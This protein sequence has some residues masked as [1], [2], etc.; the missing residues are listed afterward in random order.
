MVT[1][2]SKAAR[3]QVLWDAGHKTVAALMSRANIARRTAERYLKKLKAGESLDR[4]RYKTR[5][6][7]AQTPGIIRKV[8]SKVR[9]SKRA[10]SIR[11]I[12]TASG[13]SYGTVRTILKKHGSYA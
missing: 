10:Y 2:I 12:A 7:V 13:T 5:K 3:A 1:S 11:M 4:K 8:I 9:D 6:K